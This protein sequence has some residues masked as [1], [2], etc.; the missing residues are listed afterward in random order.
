MVVLIWKIIKIEFREMF[1]NF[2]L[3]FLYNFGNKYWSLYIRERD[4]K[5]KCVKI[6]M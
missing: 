6:Y 3:M 4:K 2:K 5:K 1:R